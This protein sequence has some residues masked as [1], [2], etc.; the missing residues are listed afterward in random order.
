MT[1]A[2]AGQHAPQPRA[3]G[4]MDVRDAPGA[5]G[6]ILD[7]P[8]ALA[9]DVLRGGTRLTQR[10][11]HGEFHAALPAMTTH[12]IMTYYGAA[13][14]SS[15][16]IGAKRTSARTRPG[17]ITIIPE[18]QDGRW[19]VEGPIEVSHVYLT[20]ERLRTAV[21]ALHGQDEPVEL[22][23]RI[24][25]DDPVA[26]RI[27]EILSLE[28]ARGDSSSSLFADQALDLLCAQLVRGHSARSAL[29]VP[30]PRKGLADWQVKR[31]TRYMQEALD[32]EIRLDDLAGL[33]QLSRFHFCTAF[34]LATGQTPHEWLTALRIGH[35]R[36][37]LATTDL[38]VTTVGLAVGYQTPSSF[39]SSFRKITGTTP[40]AFR[41][42]L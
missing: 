24:C 33:V 42:A 16:R 10:W 34:R 25:F 20:D 21:A 31:V 14:D 29:P 1:T 8:P 32:Q 4:P 19:D 9:T 15:C 30:G 35:A 26:A 6:D 2:A 28:A 36:H 27:L 18:G 11:R 12:V 38:P 13:Q 41:R 3:I 22:I 23:G 39:A 17:T 40:T 7:Q 37:L 5:I